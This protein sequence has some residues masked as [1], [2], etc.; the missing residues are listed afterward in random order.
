MSTEVWLFGSFFLLLVLNMPI[1]IALGLSAVS[2]MLI[3]DLPMQSIPSLFYS[4]TAKFTLLAIP[5]F[6]L[7]GIIMERAGISGRLINLAKTLTG[8]YTGGLAIVSVVSAC[9]FAAISGSGPATMAAVG[10][11]LIPAMVNS[12]YRKD[13]AAGLLATAGGIGIIIP[14]SIAF[15]VYGVV[16]E[17]SIGKLFIAG[18]IPGLLVGL[19][20]AVTSYFIAKRDKIPKMPRATGREIGKALREALWGLAAPVI[21]LGGIYSGVFTP[22][23]S[24]VVAVFYSLFVGLFIYRTIKWKDLSGILLQSGKTTAMI[25]LIV[26]SASVFAWLITVEGI[27]EDV[28][29]SLLGLVQSKY[30]MLFMI[31]VILLL[32]G[33]FVDAISA[34]YIFLPIFL[35]IL[36]ALQIDPVHFGVVMTMNLAIGL[37]TPPVGLDLYAACGL[38]KIS[39]KEISRG[40]IP[41]ILASLVALF[42]VTYI[43]AVALW[44]PDILGM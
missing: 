1:A 19:T 4:S 7:A 22:T 28:A 14:P 42:I 20:L 26:A 27:A 37:V 2:T 41:F 43:P 23:E 15:V 3:F 5:F 38:A 34:Y 39:L 29:D 9:F 8:H 24:A 10:S 6:F 12:G 25:M 32:A 18:I 30:A 13:M 35:P 36:A 44:L 11:I 40:V 33:M 16:A 21:I 17:V 31:N